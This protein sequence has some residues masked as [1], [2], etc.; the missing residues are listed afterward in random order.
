METAITIL[1]EL[2]YRRAVVAIFAAVAIVV[3]GLVAYRPS[4]P[5]ESRKYEVG[6][7][8]ARILLDTPASQAVEVAP[9]GSETLG[10]RANLLANLMAEGDIKAAIAKRAGLR[11]DKLYA[12]GPSS[13]GASPVAPEALRDHDANIL[14]MSV[15]TD[16]IGG[17]LPIIDIDAQAVDAKRAAALANAAVTGLQDYLATKAAADKVDDARRL[18]ARALGAAQA[19]DVARGPSPVL[20]AFAAILLFGLLCGLLLVVSALVRVWRVASDVEGEL[21]AALADDD[22]GLES[23]GAVDGDR[24]AAASGDD[25]KASA[26]RF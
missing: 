16:D 12:S 23:F 18:Q 6:E 11:A 2:W 19:A 21:S 5:P 7:A 17:Q 8:T 1:R 22:W 14:T 10:A 24:D 15:L 25:A 26:G 20:A 9:K 13:V 4:L 3:G